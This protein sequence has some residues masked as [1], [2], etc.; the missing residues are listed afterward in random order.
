MATVG[1]NK[2]PKTPNKTI[3]IANK[4][5]DK[6][7]IIDCI[8]ARCCAENS[9]CIISALAVLP[10]PKN[11]FTQAMING[12][13]IFAKRTPI[14]RINTLPN[15]EKKKRRIMPIFRIYGTIKKLIMPQICFK[16]LAILINQSE[17][18]S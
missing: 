16:N 9:F 6:K 17:T 3:T 12:V 5:P 2:S 8:V 7:E 1:P 4:I 14:P 13:N 10:V 15:I 18:K 11:K